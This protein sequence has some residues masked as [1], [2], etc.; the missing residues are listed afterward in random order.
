MSEQEV[1]DRRWDWHG[2]DREAD[3][4]VE[5]RAVDSPARSTF[6]LGRSHVWGAHSR[7]TKGN[8]RLALLNRALCE[9]LAEVFQASLWRFST[10]REIQQ[11]PPEYTHLEMEL[12]GC[13][14]D[15]LSRLLD[16]ILCARIRL[17]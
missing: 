6:G 16:K 15:V 11:P 12:S 2:A 10:I 8:D 14:D 9:S 5:E 7:L 17:V 4:T 3:E 1:G 13:E